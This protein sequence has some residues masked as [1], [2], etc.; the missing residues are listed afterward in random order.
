MN[1]TIKSMVILFV[2]IFVGF[3]ALTYGR[4]GDN[5]NYTL[6]DI[7]VYYL[8]S[9]FLMFNNFAMDPGGL[10]YGDRVFPLLRILF[11]LKT[12]DGFNE[13]R[14]LFSKLK[15]DDSQFSFFVGDFCIDFGSVFAYDLAGVY[16]YGINHIICFCY[17][18]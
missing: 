3:W 18:I 13:R 14:M 2:M 4:F 12:S 1:K 7:M 10:R 16:S 6:M 11:G 15:I 17:F 9:N 5:V 8:S